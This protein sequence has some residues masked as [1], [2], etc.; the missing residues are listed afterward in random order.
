[1]FFRGHS[2]SDRRRT[3]GGHRRAIFAALN[4]SGIWQGIADS[5]CGS[6]HD[7]DN[8]SSSTSGRRRRRRCQVY[9]YESTYQYE[10]TTHTSMSAGKAPAAPAAAM[11][12]LFCALAVL[13][14][15]LSITTVLSQN[16]R[17]QWHTLQ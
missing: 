6:G 17:G 11:L 8:S 9:E 10:Y 1:M 2:G 12:G 4:P 13:N 15:G 5:L 7:D 14:A 3:A 16:S